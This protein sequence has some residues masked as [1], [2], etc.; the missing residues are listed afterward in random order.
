MSEMS[1]T[2]HAPS[3]PPPP[4]TTISQ[5]S[6]G[7]Y[8][9]GRPTHRPPCATVHGP[10]V[11]EKEPVVREPKLGGVVCLVPASTARPSQSRREGA[12]KK[13]P[14]V[15]LT[16]NSA[17]HHAA[18]QPRLRDLPQRHRRQPQRVPRG[19]LALQRG[20]GGEVKGGLGQAQ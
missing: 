5:W 4:P 19:E 8:P 13:D 11:T 2:G 17:D 10:E 15:R 7:R 16:V 14:I 6:S 20:E 12:T 1:N 9:A 18:Q 3:L